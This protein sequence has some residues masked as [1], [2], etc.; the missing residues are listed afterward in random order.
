MTKAPAPKTKL[1]LVEDDHLIAENLKVFLQMKGFDVQWAADG[2]V[3]V[4]ASRK[5]PPDIVLLDIMLPKL[6]GFDVCRILKSD[7]KTKAAKII[8]ATGLG[9]MSDVEKAFEAGASDY[10]VKPIDNNQLLKKIEKV[11]SS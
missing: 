4:E 3:A 2:A 9:R 6:G 10:I 5:I 11:L 7:A 8:I 1:L